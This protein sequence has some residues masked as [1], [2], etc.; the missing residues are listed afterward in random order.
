LEHFLR[1]QINIEL[2]TR[3]IL[4]IVKTYQVQIKQNAEMGL[5]LKS[6]SVHM[7]SHFKDMRDRV[8]LNDCAI[9]ILRKELSD[10]KNKDIANDGLNFS[11]PTAGD[12][13]M[14]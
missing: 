14:F 10:S 5:L 2:T 3:A 6:I 1:N 9:K 12:A 7:K 11:R 8:G 13:F 4:Y